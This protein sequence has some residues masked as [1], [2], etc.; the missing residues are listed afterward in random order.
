MKTISKTNVAA[1]FLLAVFILVG[2]VSAQD[3]SNKD[4]P[5]SF[6]GGGR[7]VG[8]WEVVVTARNCQTGAPLATFPATASFN[9]EGTLLV[10]EGGIPPSLKTPAQGNWTQV[11]GRHYRFKTKAFN[12]NAAG[13][14][15]GWLIINQTLNLDRG[16]NGYETSGTAEVY[17]SQGVLVAT[18]CSTTTATRFD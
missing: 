5:R 2:S 6:F 8:T 12:F 3:E 16:A 10:S 15:T 17:N 11:W 13:T 14:L 7:I 18:N 9:S 1:M 4:E